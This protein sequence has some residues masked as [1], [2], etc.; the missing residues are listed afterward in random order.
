MLKIVTAG[1]LS[2]VA[3]KAW[4]RYQASSSLKSELDEGDTTPPHGDPILVGETLDVGP[5]PHAGAQFSRG[6][7]E[8]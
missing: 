2:Y 6:F 3:F 1:A 8:A 4:Q 7:G 5:V